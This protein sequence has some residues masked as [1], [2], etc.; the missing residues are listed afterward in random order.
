MSQHDVTSRRFKYS[1]VSRHS[2]SETCSMA[3][4]VEPVTSGRSLQG[5]RRH[6]WA[7]SSSFL[8]EAVYAI[9]AAVRR[10]A[11]SLS[12][13]SKRRA[14]KQSVTT[15]TPNSGHLSPVKY[16]AH[17]TRMSIITWRRPPNNPQLLRKAPAISRSGKHS[18]KPKQ[19]QIVTRWK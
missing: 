18:A 14:S 15:P 1:A 2:R 12:R 13:P 19:P 5:E 4:G 16:L 10:R 8:L 6:F 9:V 3:D 17:P 11:D 7:S